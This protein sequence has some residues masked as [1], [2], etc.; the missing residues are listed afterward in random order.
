MSPPGKVVMVWYSL[1]SAG[2][3]MIRNSHIISWHQAASYTRLLTEFSRYLHTERPPALPALQ[4]EPRCY[5]PA[6]S[7]AAPH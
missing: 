7:A 4:K 5:P 3:Q 6:C 1:T 2:E